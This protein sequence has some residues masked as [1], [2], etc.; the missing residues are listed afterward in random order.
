M[1]PRDNCGCNNPDGTC[2]Y[3]CEPVCREA[4]CCN[5]EPIIAVPVCNVKVTT[6]CCE[7]ENRTMFQVPDDVNGDNLCA[8]MP[9][10][11]DV[12]FTAEQK[13]AVNQII[14]A[15]L[16]VLSPYP[17]CPDTCEIINDNGH[18][19]PIKPAQQLNAE[20]QPLWYVNGNEGE[21]T[22]ERTD[23]ETGM[24]RHP[25]VQ[26]CCPSFKHS[27]FLRGAQVGQ[28]V[29]GGH[30]P[31]WFTDMDIAGAGGVAQQKLGKLFC[32]AKDVVASAP[33]MEIVE[34]S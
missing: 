15:L 5:E 7:A 32:C 25:V 19:F 12:P 24:Q 6:I 29:V 4:P 10:L 27:P 8:C 22:T 17:R 28:T 16:T 30:R 33:T 14:N 13:D 2:T 11:E 23:P 21:V 34:Q 26:E 3:D 31:H 1:P 9:C 18:L 20:G